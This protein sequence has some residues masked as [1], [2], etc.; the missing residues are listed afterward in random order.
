MVNT[1]AGGVLNKLDDSAKGPLALYNEVSVGRGGL[2][3]LVRFD[4]A[5]LLGMGCPGALG[6]GVRRVLYA[7]LFKACGRHL[8]T[9]RHVVL[10]RPNQIAIGDDVVIGNHCVLSVRGPDAR[11]VLG[12]GVQLGD[13]TMISCAG[14]VLHIEDRVHI[15]SRCRLSSLQG[16]HIGNNAQLHDD[17][18]VVGAGHASDRND[19]PVLRQEVTCNGPTAIGAWSVI[20]PSATI[21]DGVTLGKAVHVEAESLV[22]SDWNDG[23][24]VGGVPAREQEANL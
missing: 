23:V 11:I 9:G 5:M 8:H 12:N 14:G 24:F 7:G 13:R 6:R 1:G 16:L 17:V 20:E 21:L 2:W 10:R 4:G 19:I 18:C 3:A 15:G 22:H